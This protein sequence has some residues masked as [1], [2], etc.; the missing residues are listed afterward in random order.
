MRPTFTISD[1]SAT[2]SQ[3]T[4][5]FDDVADVVVPLTLQTFGA[6]R[7]LLGEQ[8]L[9]MHNALLFLLVL[10][11]AYA[12][13]MAVRRETLLE[14][15]WAD[16]DEPRQRGNLRQSL[17]KLR[18]MGVQT[19]LRGDVVYLEPTQVHRTFSLVPSIEAFERDITRGSEPYGVFLPD[20]KLPTPAL[21]EWV[22]RTREAMHGSVRRVLV[23]VLRQRRERAD[24]KGTQMVA[25]WLLQLDPLNEDGTLA[26]AEC[27][28]L[29]GSK[30][31]AIAILDRYLAELGPAAGDIRLPATLLRKRFADVP[32][33]RRSVAL[34]TD[35]FFVGREDDLSAMTR[36][37]R[38][39]RW[40]DGSVVLVHG[41]PGMGKS[42]LMAEVVK[43]AQFEGYHDIVME[44][45]ESIT[46][47]P[48]G[49]LME[50]LPEL[51]NAPGSMGCAPESLTILR[52]LLGP[53]F[54]R[55]VDEP[56]DP[57]IPEPSPDLTRTERIELAIRTMRAQSIRHAVVDLFAAVSDERPIF[58][59]V[60]DVHWLDDASWEVLSDVMQRVNE[61]RVYIVLTSRFPNIREERPARVPTPLTYRKLEP[62]DA[63]SLSAMIRG[64][65]NEHGLVV[66]DV[67][68]RWV[69]AGCEGNPLMLRALLEHWAVTGLSEGVPPSL[70]SLIDQRI[71]RLDA[72][73]QQALQATSLLGQF[74]TSDRV[75][76][77]LEFPVHEL[78]RAIEQ[79]ELASC[80]SSSDSALVITHGLVREVAIRRMSPLIERALRASIAD[81]LEAEYLKTGD[82]IVLHEA[83]AHTELSGRTNVLYRYL[84]QHH[85]A[86]I[87]GGRPG[88]VLRAIGTLAAS[89]PHIHEERHF[90]ILQSR[91]NTQ[92]GAYRR[93]IG[94]LLGSLKLPN[95]ISALSIDEI[96]E[97]IAIV[98]AA[99]RADPIIDRDQ[100]ARFAARLTKHRE[101]PIATRA[102][103]AEVALTITANTCDAATA[104]SCFEAVYG[105]LTVAGLTDA[106]NRLSLLF[107]A[108][109]GDI[110]TA[111]HT[112][113]T[114]IKNADR[115]PASTNIAIDLSRAAF[116]LRLCGFLDESVTALKRHFEMSLELK[117]PR[118]GL[119]S[120]WQI[121]QIDLERGDPSSVAFWNG[122]LM[123]ILQ[124]D[125]D[126]I[127]SSFVTAHF[128]RCAIDERERQQALLLLSQVK[129]RQPKLPTKKASAYVIALEIGSA[130][131]STRATV[132]S[133]LLEA[134]IERH[135]QT[136][137]YGT[138]D[139]LT[140]MIAEGLIRAGRKEEALSLVKEYKKS[141]RRERGPLSRALVAVSK[142]LGVP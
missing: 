59:L 63:S 112:A 14:E 62:L 37:L 60:E 8:S 68:E 79:L 75:K 56:A 120:A 142:K 65:A 94:N 121:A 12:P 90:Q 136:A 46:T 30:A 6:A 58:L 131:L 44:C 126:P 64:V 19:A 137:L 67:V 10:R 3:P 11:L 5:S 25:Q 103:A 40:H 84:T 54:D 95:D 101:L 2:I 85:E 69:I 97:L 98:D 130:L 45:R 36:S 116:A 133:D 66:D 38:R 51:M 100:L 77:V 23:E 87:D 108:I 7:I 73:A 115:R 53:D 140:A 105:E 125:D 102:R 49:A 88:G 61:M 132:S 13:S 35:K 78:I 111:H 32:Q 50:I 74:A 33:R 15:F 81:V 22:D 31:E 4:D 34:V 39:A 134:A 17:Y 43:V 27:A 139:F 128:C 18:T 124:D 141:A 83:L 135:Q 55:T 104:T 70:S 24:W 107:H 117:L 89:M 41:P 21:Q 72:Q 42:R 109:F 20:I 76:L 122:K 138:S 119:Y 29:T 99:H 16:Q 118:L 113:K 127:S 82:T 52:K 48:L 106:S 96:E 9:G 71:E 92:A 86:L 26:L 57:P 114:I 129:A 110:E 1:L 80:L 93:A 28:A 91:L 47:R 123:E